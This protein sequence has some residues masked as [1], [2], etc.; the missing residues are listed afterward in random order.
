MSSYKIINKTGLKHFVTFTV[1]NWIDIFTKPIYFEILIDSLKFYQKSKGLV[2][3]GY[4]IMTNHLHL[5]IANSIEIFPLIDIIRDYKKY[6][7]RQIF[8]ELQNDNRIYLEELLREFRN[9][10]RNKKFQ[11]WQRD[12]HPIFIESEKFFMQKLN[13]IHNNPVR[14]SYVDKQEDWLYSSAKNYFN[15]DHL[16]IKI[17]NC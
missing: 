15:D 17:K 10:K 9:D 11:L 8:N 16:I 13:Y 1:I 2:I 6:T 7:A 14:K 5:I 4:V 3:Y 12:N